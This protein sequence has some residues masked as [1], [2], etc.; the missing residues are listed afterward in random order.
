[1]P[2]L[3]IDAKIKFG[4]E[5]GYTDKGCSKKY[6]FWFVLIRLIEDCLNRKNSLEVQNH[7]EEG[8]SVMAKRK[9]LI[10]KSTEK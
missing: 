8:I 9:T 1:M 2:L 5:N 6:S 3:W 4:G 7:Y 10:F